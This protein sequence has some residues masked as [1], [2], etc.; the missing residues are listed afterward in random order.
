MTARF[1]S[2]L[3]VL[4]GSLALAAA[5]LAPLAQ[6][7]ELDPA[8]AGGTAASR[9]EVRAE[10]AAALRNG[11]VVVNAETGQT[12]RE[13]NPKRYPQPAKA[14][15][16]S[17]QDVRAETVAAIRSGDVIDAESGKKLN[18]LNPKRYAKAKAAPASASAAK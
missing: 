8:P 14:D 18:E 10:R 16:K 17:R 6:A 4:L 7:N 2:A 5:T 3:N 9:A 12:A 13:V 11:D 1:S 15:T